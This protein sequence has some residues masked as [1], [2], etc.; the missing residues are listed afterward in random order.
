MKN[1]VLTEF[2]SK[3]WN[4]YGEEMISRYERR[5][6]EE[7]FEALQEKNDQKIKE[8]IDGDYWTEGLSGWDCSDSPLGV[9]VYKIEHDF[10]DDWC[11]YCGEPEERK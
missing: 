2:E 11:P 8:D 6:K 7:E 9:C 3:I 10:A 1:K 4:L 5:L